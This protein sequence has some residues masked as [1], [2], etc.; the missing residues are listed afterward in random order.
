M[1]KLFLVFLAGG[2]MFTACKKEY[3]EPLN[4]NRKEVLMIRNPE[5][6]LV[7]KEYVS[8]NCVGELYINRKNI[9]DTLF[10]I[11]KFLPNNLKTST[12]WEGT[13]EVEVKPVGPGLN[14]VTYLCTGTPH[15]C[16]GNCSFD[17]KG[18]IIGCKI[19]ILN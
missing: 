10:V 11:K 6:I 1:K 5:F 17:S 18:N 8:E 16:R 7:N 19:N 15:N 9:A 4:A 12:T 3:N 2:I 13:L 14:E